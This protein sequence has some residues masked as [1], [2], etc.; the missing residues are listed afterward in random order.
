MK[1]VLVGGHPKG[2][3]EPF[4]PKT[5]SGKTLRK[6]TSDLNIKP[7][8][9]DLWENQEQM[10][11]GKVKNSVVNELNRFIKNDHTIIALGRFTEVAL[12]ENEIECKY[13]P[14]PASRDAKYLK[15]LRKELEKMMD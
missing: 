10:D 5:K 3:D 12:R 9:F 1:I 15:Q 6:I 4:H 14:H 2:F 8:F 13:L 7:V 11:N